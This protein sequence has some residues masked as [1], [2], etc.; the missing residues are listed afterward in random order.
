MSEGKSTLAE[1][2]IMALRDRV[3]KKALLRKVSKGAV[4]AYVVAN[5]SL[6]RIP[7]REIR[8]CKHGVVWGIDLEDGD[9]IKLEIKSLRWPKN[10]L[11]V[12]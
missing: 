9:A 3:T 6:V 5:Q 7:Y 2:G 1:F 4:C 8:K 11:R 12:T 10:D